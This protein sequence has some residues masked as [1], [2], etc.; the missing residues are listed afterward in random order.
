MDI[1]VTVCPAS[2]RDAAVIT[3]ILNRSIQA[4]CAADH[5]NDARVIAAWSRNKSLEHVCTWLDD[6]NL[7][8]H[9]GL[10]AGKPVGVA[11]ARATGQVYLCY[12]QPECFRRGVGQALMASLEQR[13]AQAGRLCAGLYSSPSARAFYRRLGY[14]ETGPAV[15]VFGL[16]FWP[17]AK[18]LARVA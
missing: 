12:V 8:L 16:C 5:R 9:L 1:P 3:R 13:L 2:V 11:L 6:T 15:S 17:M 7:Y 14:R 18:S 4:G 10:L